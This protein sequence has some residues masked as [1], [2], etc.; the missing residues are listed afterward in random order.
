MS[1]RSYDFSKLDGKVETYDWEDHHS[2][3]IQILFEA[4]ESIHQFL[5]SK[6]TCQKIHL[7]LVRPMVFIFCKLHTIFSVREW[8]KDEKRLK[9]EFEQ[10]VM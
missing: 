8:T 5:L 7:F 1:G 2:P 9:L 6:F 10:V 3:A 4:C